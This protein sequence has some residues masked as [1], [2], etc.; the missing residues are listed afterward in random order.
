MPARHGQFVSTC[1]ALLALGLAVLNV[2]AL[3]QPA[4][5]GP[6]GVRMTW[7]GITNWPSQM[8]DRA[9]MPDGAVSFRS[10]ATAIPVKQ[11]I[12]KALVDEVH[13]ALRKAGGSIDV[14]LLGHRHS[15]HSVD[16]PYWALKTKARYF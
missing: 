8:G 2:E 12:N 9:I 5:P 3:A 4:A 6:S 11:E 14:M 1:I 10:S 13:D 7:F 16:S 15:D